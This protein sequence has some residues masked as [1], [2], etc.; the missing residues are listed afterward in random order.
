MLNAQIAIYIALPQGII[1]SS[2]INNQTIDVPPSINETKLTETHC[3]IVEGVAIR[4]V[5]HFSWRR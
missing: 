3:H 1:R 5:S 2:P 4:N